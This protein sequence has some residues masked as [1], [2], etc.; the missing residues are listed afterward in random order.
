VIRAGSQ[1]P[2]VAWLQQQLALVQ[3]GIFEARKAGWF[4]DALARR[5]R[6]F[7]LAEGLLPDGIAGPKTLIRL[8]AA[9]GG[10]SPELAEE[11]MA[12]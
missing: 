12:R 5:V 4:D 1:G 11:R 2:D 9:T 10:G 3:G 8:D 6:R 7:Q